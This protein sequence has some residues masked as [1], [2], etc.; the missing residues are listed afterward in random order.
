M[1]AAGVGL[2]GD[3]QTSLYLG[4]PKSLL[5][6]RCQLSVNHFDPDFHHSPQATPPVQR[7][8][9]HQ[10]EAAPRGAQ[11]LLDHAQHNLAAMLARVEV[12]VG[13]SR[14][15]HIED[16]VQAHANPAGF[17]ERQHVFAYTAQNLGLLLI[18][19]GA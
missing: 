18:R 9:R 17:D 10:H 4:Y 19:T 2:C 1:E 8:L 12:L 11:R 16:T 13:G 6:T 3:P 14:L 15:L 7:P 5:V